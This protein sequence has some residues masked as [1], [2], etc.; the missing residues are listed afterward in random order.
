MFG[1]A[2]FSEVPYSAL[3]VVG[4]QVYTSAIV[5]AATGTDAVSARLQYIRT[6]VEF[7]SVTDAAAAGFLF[8]RAIA[9]TATGSDTDNA[10]L[11]ARGVVTETATGTDTDSASKTMRG[12]VTE[13]ATGTDADSARLS[14]LGILQET[15][16]ITDAL[17]APGSTYRA[18]VVELATLQ[19]AARAAA[20][21][22][23]AVTEAA[24]GTETVRAAF[25][26]YAN[27]SESATITDATSALA[28]FA[29]RT[30]ESAA[31]TD[32][33]SPPG[34]IYNPVVLAVAQIT[35]RV[36]PPGSIYNAPVLESATI[37]DALIGGYLWN[38]INTAEDAGWTLIAPTSTTQVNGLWDSS[39]SN[40]NTALV[41]EVYNSFTA[42]PTT[43]YAVS[44][45]S[46]PWQYR[47]IPGQ[48]INILRFVNGYFYAYSRFTANRLYRSV[49]GFAWEQLQAPV[50]SQAVR[51]VFG[52]GTQLIVQQ[53][54]TSLYVSTDNGATWTT[55]AVTDNAR[56]GATAV[57][58]GSMYVYNAG[59]SV[60]TS[61]D[62]LTWTLRTSGGGTYSQRGA[63]AYV[64]GYYLALFVSSVNNTGSL[65]RISQDGI[66]WTTL[67]LA[68]GVFWAMTVFV[69]G[70][71]FIYAGPLFTNNSTTQYVL[72][73][74]V[75]RSQELL[76]AAPGYRMD[77]VSGDLAVSLYRGTYLLPTYNSTVVN[78]FLTSTDMRS[79]APAYV[80]FWS[81]IDDSQSPGWQNTPTLN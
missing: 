44:T 62:G 2:S 38:L 22:P 45:Q 53:D 60:Y 64:N 25:I 24:T 32:Q 29:A 12:V 56:P 5:E 16:A 75:T 31:I 37:T 3:P 30:A 19:D 43:P 78:Q 77:L 80:Y 40:G 47:Q 65:M 68:I 71:K 73:D 13:T 63:L 18:P 61:T 14:A 7:G 81:G 52:N 48:N 1:F 9:E 20:T 10:Q 66:T 8:F 50:P 17:N 26:P 58:N 33:V 72:L 4:N 67:P 39:A 49:D 15:A 42:L 55:T 36:S 28:A 76:G 21:F 57:W 11:S 6:I 69:Y 27:I 59:R 54:T 41:L 70:D 23:V 46:G 74:P 79:F 34:S 51:A 35:D